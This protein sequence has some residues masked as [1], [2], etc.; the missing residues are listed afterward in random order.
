MTK[1]RLWWA[2]SSAV[3]WAGVAAAQ[4]PTSA[5]I[6]RPVAALEGCWRGTGEAVGKHVA[7][8]LA[9]R[10]IL[11]R[12]MVSVDVESHTLG[13]DQDRYSAHLVFGGLEPAQA[14]TKDD[15]VAFW[16]DTFGGAYAVMGR[17][18]SLRD[19]FDVTYNYPDAT[20][21]NRWRLEQRGLRWVIVQRDHT[22][23]EKPFATYSLTSAP[24]P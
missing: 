12:A 8:A 18:R 19:G 10:R 7:V 21:V 2:A 4:M 20:F 15:V 1:R 5:P 3:L 24:C 22:G 13:N 17:G 6:P 23:A 16:S 14:V 11:D 9:V